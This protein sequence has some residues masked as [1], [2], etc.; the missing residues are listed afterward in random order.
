MVYSEAIRATFVAA[1]ALVAASN[2]TCCSVNGNRDA[3]EEFGMQWWCFRGWC[4]HTLSPRP[5]DKLRAGRGRGQGKGGYF[6]VSITLVS[7]ITFTLITPG[8]VSSF[9]IFCAI[10]FASVRCCKSSTFSAST[11]T[12]TSRPALIA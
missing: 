3:S 12:R 4:S 8:Y 9:S 6:A 5:F 1:T 10:S 7:R 2:N 11:K